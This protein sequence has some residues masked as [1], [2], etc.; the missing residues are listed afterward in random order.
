MIIVTYLNKIIC[1]FYCL[2]NLLYVQGVFNVKNV[3]FLDCSTKKLLE[4]SGVK[5]KNLTLDK[6]NSIVNLSDYYRI[7]NMTEQLREKGALLDKLGLGFESNE[8]P[9]LATQSEPYKL[10]NGVLNGYCS[11]SETII[12][13]V[14]PSNHSNYND[15]VRQSAVNIA[16]GL[17]SSL[18]FQKVKQS[19]IFEI[20]YLL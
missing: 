19:K 11:N 20:A 6:L 4:E 3:I 15:M 2:C 13:W 7:T 10:E 1:K 12:I 17:R 16:E 8:Y 18:P 14:E 5:I 9:S